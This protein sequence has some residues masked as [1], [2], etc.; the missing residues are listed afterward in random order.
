[1]TDFSS[2]RAAMLKNLPSIFYRAIVKSC[3]D[4]PR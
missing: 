4:S 1:M 3:H 2:T